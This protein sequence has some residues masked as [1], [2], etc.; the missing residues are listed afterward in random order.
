MKRVI[1]ILV[2]LIFCG[3]SAGIGTAVY[4]A[5][6]PVKPLFILTETYPI[7]EK[8]F[9]KNVF[10]PGEKLFY[11]RRGKLLNPVPRE[12]HMSLYNDDSEIPYVRLPPNSGL[13]SKV[14]PFE[15]KYFAVTLPHDLPEGNYSFRAVM[16]YR[17]N[18]IRD[19]ASQ[20]APRVIFKVQ[21]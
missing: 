1:D 9:P 7:D 19:Y 8:G 16:F 3:L 20:E 4:F 12:V 2:L 13:Q 6:E 10:K 11:Y 14:G 5:L 21:R 17:L 15:Q 18:V